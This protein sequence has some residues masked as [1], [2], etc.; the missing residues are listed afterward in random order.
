MSLVAVGGSLAAR[1][2]REGALTLPTMG[3]SHTSVGPGR[4]QRVSGTAQ[5]SQPLQK[6]ITEVPK[7][8]EEV[9][10]ISE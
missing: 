10:S 2:A 6:Q 7:G 1:R 5:R 4:G 9:D 8:P 3:Q